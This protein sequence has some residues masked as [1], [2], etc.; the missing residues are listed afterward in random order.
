[1]ERENWYSES[2]ADADR[3]FLASAQNAGATIQEFPHPLP[4]PTGNELKTIVARLGSEH[5]KRVIVVVSG[6]HGVE[7]YAG[8]AIQ[9]A[10]LAKQGGRELEADEALIVIHLIN[11][12]GCAWD[13]REDHE[14]IDIFRNLV[15]ADPP[16]KENP[17]YD[18]YEEGINPRAWTG[19]LR[20]RSNAILQDFIRE[21]GMAGVI[22]ALRRGQHNHP[23]GITY[24][25]SGPSWSRLVVEEIARTY[26]AGAEEIDVLDI[27]TGFGAHGEGV[28][29]SCEEPGSEKAEWVNQRF[30]GMLYEWGQVGEIPDHPHGPYHLIERITGE[31]TVRNFGIEYGTHDLSQRI[32]TIREAIYVSNREDRE[33]EYARKVGREIRECYYPASP[34][35]REKVLQHGLGV[36]S[37]AIR[38]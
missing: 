4:G 37:K 9:S 16:F 10:Y 26:L 31:G 29:I 19:P 1:M 35:W 34:E 20:E 12:W 27:H 17:L 13:R 23:K 3:L 8:S 24:H 15:Y 28:I 18:R 2:V 30:A 14:N 5:P 38:G 32:D 6:T 36:V 7:G 22:T 11:P 33:G 25:G 21:H